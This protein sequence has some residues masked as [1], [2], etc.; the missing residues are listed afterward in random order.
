IRRARERPRPVPFPL[1][2][3]KGR[4]IL[5]RCR[6]EIPRPLSLTTTVAQS[7]RE[8]T[9]TSTV[10][11]PSRPLVGPLLIT[12][13]LLGSFGKSAFFASQ[14]KHLISDP[15]LLSAVLQVPGSGNGPWPWQRGLEGSDS[16]PRSS[17]WAASSVRIESSPCGAAF[18]QVE[19]RSGT[20][21]SVAPGGRTAG[22]CAPVPHRLKVVRS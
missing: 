18:S 9:L 5:G 21:C 12:H 6:G 14:C 22:W 19:P 7:P 4:K 2:V 3:K 1:V 17:A 16:S 20:P 15:L 11:S 10:P 8:P 13:D